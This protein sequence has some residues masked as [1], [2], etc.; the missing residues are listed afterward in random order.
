VHV[1]EHAVSQPP[2]LLGSLL[3]STQPPAHAVSVP[4]VELSQA[5][6]VHEPDEQT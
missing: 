1:P 3:V 6:F 4:H 5:L 2:Q